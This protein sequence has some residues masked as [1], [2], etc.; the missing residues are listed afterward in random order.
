[1]RIKVFYFISIRFSENDEEH[2]IKKEII[3]QNPNAHFKKK[4]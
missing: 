2:R 1:M 4:R 3:E